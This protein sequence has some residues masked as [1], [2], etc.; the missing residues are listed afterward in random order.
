MFDLPNNEAILLDYTAILPSIDPV[1]AF[2]VA[3]LP[4]NRAVEAIRAGLPARAFVGVA[5]VLDITVDELAAKLGVS[6]RT[7]RDQR[8]K[9]IRLSSGNT[10]K[11]VR[12]ARIQHRARQIFST[13]E[14]VSG[15]LKSPA[16]ALEGAHPIDLLDTDLGAREVEVVLNGIAY[17][18][19]M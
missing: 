12:I 6:A 16:P 19:V 10:E 4:T 11:L 17:G 7:I 3:E 9:S 15:W 18:N 14:A 2:D 1:T 5:E 8:K 13:D